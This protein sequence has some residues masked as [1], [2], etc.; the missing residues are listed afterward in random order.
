METLVS[1][2]WLSDALGKGNLGIVDATWFMPGSGRDAQ[3]EFEDAH[4]PGAVFFDLDA[5]SDPGSPLPHM[6]PPA[7]AFG[8]AMAQLGLD[9]DSPIV[10]YDN[11][12][13]RSAARA[14]WM[15][16]SFGARNVAVLDGGLAKW[17]AEARP[18]ERG[19]EMRREGRFE[20]PGAPTAI[21]DLAHVARAVATGGTEIVD[22]RSPARFEG[23]EPEPRPGLASGHIPGAKNVPYSSLFASDG[24]LLGAERLREAFEDAGVDL[25]RPMIT[26]CGS[27]VTAA[28][29]LLAAQ[30]LGKDDVALY[31]G[32]WAEWGADPQTP[33]AVGAR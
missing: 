16:R 9:S 17:R 12:P 24:T 11:S 15:L 26:T 31:D 30:R 33:K 4:I 32:S 14:W 1:T 5:V 3:A 8:T 28:V 18:L 20:A 10:V 27:G 2:Q 7:G 22:A 29:L 25:D 6:M 19:P 13:V 21:A 23:R